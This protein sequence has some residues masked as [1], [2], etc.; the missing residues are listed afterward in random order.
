MQWDKRHQINDPNRY[1]VKIDLASAKSTSKLQ[2]VTHKGQG[3]LN[4]KKRF[5]V[6]TA[7]KNASSCLGSNGKPVRLSEVQL[8][9]G[10]AGYQVS[11]MQCCRWFMRK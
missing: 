10:G 9:G 1:H 6:K 5:R 7:E 4:V 3:L 11:P 8:D 2:A